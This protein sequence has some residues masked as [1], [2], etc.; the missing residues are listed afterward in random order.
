M[1][2]YLHKDLSSLGSFLHQWMW[3]FALPQKRSKIK[4][5]EFSVRDVFSHLLYNQQTAFLLHSVP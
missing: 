2:I 3:D 4:T 1:A 5:F